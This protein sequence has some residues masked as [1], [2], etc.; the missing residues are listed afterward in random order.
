MEKAA[1][2]PGGCLC[3]PNPARPCLEWG[4]SRVGRGGVTRAEW[5]SWDC[6]SAVEPGKKNRSGPSLWCPPH[7]PE[8]PDTHLLPPHGFKHLLQLDAELLDVVHQDA[9]LEG[10]DGGVSTSTRDCNSPP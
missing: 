3:A 5:R 2:P 4:E 7:P 10:Q 1:G 9:G 8:T 6:S